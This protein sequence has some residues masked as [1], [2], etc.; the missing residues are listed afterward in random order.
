MRELHVSLADNKINRYLIFNDTSKQNR[1][2]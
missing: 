1:F 2:N